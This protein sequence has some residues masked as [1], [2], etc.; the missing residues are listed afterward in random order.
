MEL[1]EIISGTFAEMGLILI[2]LAV[3]MGA[4]AAIGF[5]VA[6]LISVPAM[7]IRYVMGIISLVGFFVWYKEFFEAPCRVLFHAVQ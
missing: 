2:K 1:Q 4:F 5:V 7:L 3:Y 6:K